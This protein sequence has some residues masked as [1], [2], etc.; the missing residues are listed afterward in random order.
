MC[1]RVT[2]SCSDL[3]GSLGGRYSR[4]ASKVR[5][6]LSGASVLKHSACRGHQEDEA[7][8]LLDRVSEP[9]TKLPDP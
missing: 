1:K 4:H 8:G 2:C 5:D 3:G 9:R 7:G 6:A